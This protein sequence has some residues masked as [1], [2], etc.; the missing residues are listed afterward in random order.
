MVAIGRLALWP[1][2]VRV[3][4][5]LAGAPEVLPAP[6]K[7]QTPTAGMEAFLEAVASK[8]GAADAARLRQASSMKVEG[9]DLVLRVQPGPAATL[10]AIQEKLPALEKLAQEM[11]LA[12]KARLVLEERAPTLEEQAAADARVQAALRVF[13][14]RITKVEEKS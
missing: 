6:E 12:E 2:L 13:R 1:R 9:E 11:G 5:L 4:H 3:E 14:G 8:L 10:K 7:E